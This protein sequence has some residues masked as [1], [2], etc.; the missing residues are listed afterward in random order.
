MKYSIKYTHMS[1]PNSSPEYALP[2][3]APSNSFPELL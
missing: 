3:I 1:T 2:N